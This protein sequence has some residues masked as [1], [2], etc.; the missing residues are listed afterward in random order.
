MYLFR[1]SVA[2]FSSWRMFSPLETSLSAYD[3]CRLSL[4]DI[5]ASVRVDEATLELR[6]M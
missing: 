4:R 5:R 3:Y 2:G 1:V 6:A